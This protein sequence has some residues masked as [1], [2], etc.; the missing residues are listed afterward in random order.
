[1]KTLLISNAQSG[2]SDEET[3][4]TI[5]SVLRQLGDVEPISPTSLESFYDEVGAA[6]RRSDLIV[7]AG[8]DGTFNSMINALKDDLAGRSFGLVPMGTGNDL[9]RTLGLPEDPVEAARGLVDGRERSLDVSRASGAGV[10]RLFVNACMGGFPVDVNEAIE[11]GDLKKRLGPLA[12]WVGGAK[13]LTNMTRFTAQVNDV[14][15]E[16]CVAVGVGNGKTCG[17]GIEVWPDADPADG[18]L[19]ACALPV[20]GPAEAVKLAAKVRD[21]KHLDIEGVATTRGSRIEISA[22]EDIEFNVDGE[23]VD[24][25][26]PAVFEI[27]DALT[28]RVP[29]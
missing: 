19:D 12:F 18:Q 26:A 23:L 21:G 6:G 4:A 22:S 24:L 14:E 16:N 15:V 29:A 1:M 8:G 5:A 3:V 10:E 25:S 28:I 2:G 9:A 20:T 13:A 17:G 27:V 7:V 11:G